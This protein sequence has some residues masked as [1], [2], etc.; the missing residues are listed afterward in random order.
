MEEVIGLVLV[1]GVVV[2]VRVKLKLL[3]IGVLELCLMIIG[4]SPGPRVHAVQLSTIMTHPLY[5]PLPY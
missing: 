1:V 4:L 3:Q 5:F 2:V